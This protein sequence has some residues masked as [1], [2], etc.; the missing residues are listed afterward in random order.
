[1]PT[2]D[3]SN[4]A[5]ICMIVNAQ[6]SVFHNVFD[7]EKVCNMYISSNFMM[8]IMYLGKEHLL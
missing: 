7:S 4:V 1:M 5:K 8:H 2:S 3:T 6:F